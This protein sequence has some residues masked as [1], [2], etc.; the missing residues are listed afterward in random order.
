MN[1]RENLYPIDTHKN[2]IIRDSF[3]FV[4]LNNIDYSYILINKY[5]LLPKK[6]IIKEL[7]EANILGASFLLNRPPQ[8]CRIGP[9]CID[10]R[11]RNCS[12]ITIW[13]DKYD[14]ILKW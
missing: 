5:Y 7:S 9:R 10:C 13:K 12:H 1:L 2:V 4:T 6:Y 8:W 11:S 3:I 14:S